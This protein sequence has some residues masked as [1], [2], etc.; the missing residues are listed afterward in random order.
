M[1]A[2]VGVPVFI[3]LVRRRRIAAAVTAIR[4]R[5]ASAPA[6]VARPRASVRRSR[7]R[8]C[9]LAARARAW[10]RSAPA[11]SRSRPAAVVDDAARRRRRRRASSSSTSCGCRASL[12][13]LSVGA[14]LGIS[15]AI[16]QSLTRN[17]LGSP[18]ILGFRPGRGDRRAHRRS[19]VLGGGG[20]RRR[21]RGALVGGVL[22]RGCVVYVLAFKRGGCPGFRLVLVGIGIGRADARAQR[23]SCSRAPASR[24]PRRRR[25]GCSAASTAALGAGRAAR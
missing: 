22:D 6:A 1:I 19:C 13:A 24:R 11:S 25:A 3:A 4:D 18:D 12:A 23:T 21:R 10:S 14:A 5:P 17:P 9:S 15:G 2:F 8:R 20:A 7:V 16:F